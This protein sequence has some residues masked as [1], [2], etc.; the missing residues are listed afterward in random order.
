MNGYL[1][2]WFGRVFCNVD[3]ESIVQGGGDGVFQPPVATDNGVAAGSES[4]RFQSK[5]IRNAFMPLDHFSIGLAGESFLG[6]QLRK[7]AVIAR[8]GDFESFDRFLQEGDMF[9]RLEE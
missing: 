4:L 8:V 7:R 2:A 3:E 1:R 9:F 5:L 6:K